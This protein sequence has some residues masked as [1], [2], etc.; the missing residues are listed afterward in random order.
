[1]AVKPT[2][3]T[4]RCYSVGFGDCFLLTFHYPGNTA[5]GTC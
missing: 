5:T 3:L 2:G 4:F 1:M